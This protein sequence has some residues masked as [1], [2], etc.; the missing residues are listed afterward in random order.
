MDDV[1]IHA[2]IEELVAEEHEL[3]QGEAKPQALPARPSAAG[4]SS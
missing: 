2:Q 4:S 1:K 3:W